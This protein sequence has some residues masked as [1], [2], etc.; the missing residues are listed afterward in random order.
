MKLLL[1]R[2]GPSLYV[3]NLS[4]AIV[5][6]LLSGG[7]VAIGQVQSFPPIGGSSSQAVHIHLVALGTSATACGA[8]LGFRLAR[9][10]EPV[11]PSETANLRLGETKTISLRLDSLGIG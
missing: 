2:R 9:T 8:R 7:A 6:L 4:H 5:M 1:T 3:Q 11:G 10:G